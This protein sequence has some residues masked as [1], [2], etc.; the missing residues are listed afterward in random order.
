[1]TVAS[2]G[3]VLERKNVLPVILH[4]DH[5]PAVLLRLVVKRL[6]EGADLAVGQAG[7]GAV[8]VFARSIVMQHEHLEPRASAGAGPLKHL[9]VAGRIAEGRVGTLADHEVNSFR[10]ASVV[11]VEQQLRVLGQEWLAILSIAKFRS[12]RGADHVLG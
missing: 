3:S 5:R 4:A 1:M 7:G 9:P 11:V 6:R 8:S 10:L 12:A 2:I